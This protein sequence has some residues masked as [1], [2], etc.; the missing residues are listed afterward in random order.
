[1]YKCRL[2]IYQTKNFKKEGNKIM[3]KNFLLLI[4]I[5]LLVSVL[6]G[7]IRSSSKTSDATPGDSASGTDSS[8]QEETSNFNKTG[9]PIVKEPITFKAMNIQRSNGG[10]WGEDM[11]FFRAMKKLTNIDFEFTNIP[12]SDWTTKMNLSLAADDPYDIYFDSIGNENIVNYGVKGGKLVDY[13]GMID[14]YMPHLK[15]WT[16]EWP[17]LLKVVTEID[18]GIYTFPRLIAGSGDHA[19]TMSVRLDYMHAAGIQK[20]PETIDEFYA[21]LKAIQKANADKEE[22]YTYLDSISANSNFERYIIAA[23][24]DYT[25]SRWHDDGTGKV[26]FNGVSDQFYRYLEFANK[27]F[28]EKIICNDIYTMDSA[29]ITALK[30]AN[31]V[32]V[33]MSF[34][35]LDESNFES[36]KT[37][38]TILA[39]LTSQY[40]SVKKTRHLPGV[41][42]TG[43]VITKHCKNVEA[44]LRYL[45][46]SYAKEDVAPGLNTLS[47][48]MGV[49]GETWD[50]TDETKKYYRF[51]T[52]PDWDRSSTEFI[53]TKCGPSYIYM[54]TMMAIPVGSSPGLEIK[55]T[56]SVEKLFPYMVPNF[57][58]DFLKFTDEQFEEYTTLWSDINSYITQMTAKFIIG[59]EPLSNYEKYV[60]TM[61]NMGLPRLI[62]IVQEAYDRFNGK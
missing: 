45:D 41:Q 16:K 48:W 37:E 49:R 17:E 29:T 14:D 22:F 33:S 31:K 51:I 50:Y 47:T 40:T 6:T 11:S 19:V 46:I 15:S 35:M 27:L 62:E 57:P 18:G 32:A 13:S 44:L 24:G 4:T 25:S 8:S 30:K 2:A 58:I 21:M 39:P 26:I 54:N 42:T 36:G 28:T 60:E 10:P 5:L 55:C 23:L 53:Y 12:A 9:Y 34:T 61:N 43:I 1:M 59:E 7:C 52:P 20:E 56:H 3:R 38:F